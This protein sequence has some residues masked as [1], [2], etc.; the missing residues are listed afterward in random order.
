M[1]K[2][3]SDKNIILFLL[4][5]YTLFTLFIIGKNSYD[6]L[7]SKAIRISKT[8]VTPK[9]EVKPQPAQI[10]KIDIGPIKKQ[11]KETGLK[12]QDARYYRVI[13]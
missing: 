1:K 4:I 12:P 2:N 9:E 7:K 6:T 5:F 11:L 8:D 3:G 13:K 10:S